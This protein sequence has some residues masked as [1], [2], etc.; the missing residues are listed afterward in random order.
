MEEETRGMEGTRSLGESDRCSYPDCEE[1][2]INV[3]SERC[4][5]HQ[6]CKEDECM[7]TAEKNGKCS[8]HGG[9]VQCTYLDCVE[10]PQPDMLGRCRKHQ[11]CSE[12]GCMLTALKY[13]RCTKH[14]GGVR[15][16]CNV[17]GCNRQIV[18]KRSDALCIKH[19]GGR[20]C[21]FPKCT[22]GAAKGGKCI[23]HGGGRRCEVEGC[24]KGAQRGGIPN[25][26]SMHGGGVRCS[27][28]G[29]TKSRVRADLCHSHT[30]ARCKVPNCNR[31]V[32]LAK[33]G[34]E[35]TMLCVVHGG[36]PRKQCEAVGCSSLARK[37]GRCK[38]HGGGIRC[39][40]KDCTTA[41]QV[42][43]L[44]RK[45]GG[46]HTC[47]EPSCAKQV[48]RKNARCWTHG[49]HR[50][51][52]CKIRP[53][54]KRS[55]CRNCLETKDDPADKGISPKRVKYDHSTQPPLPPSNHNE[56]SSGW[57]F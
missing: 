15:D 10:K 7:N 53:W 23:A 36:K 40:F 21:D 30:Q 8:F 49:G 51:K 2:S 43:E 39:K 32:Y 38:L 57:I 11:Y 28:P 41:A 9:S 4:E 33:A 31:N 18:G 52:N 50:C 22:K 5:K 26:C 45:H 35:S 1:R 47:A 42:N 54:Y 46:V 34:E 56:K 13:G 20:R 25:R 48:E 3:I 27:V 6:Y 24:G 14:G 29:C 44:C 12:N 17:P 19:G 37:G 55:L 16:C